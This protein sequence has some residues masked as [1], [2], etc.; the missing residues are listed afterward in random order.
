MAGN[1]TAMSCTKHVGIGYKFV[2]KYVD[3]GIVKAGSVSIIPTKKSVENNMKS[4]KT[5][6]ARSLSDYQ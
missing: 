1:V 2:N 4:T 3:D 5:F 6:E